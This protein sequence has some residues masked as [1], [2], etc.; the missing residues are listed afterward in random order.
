[1]QAKSGRAKCSN[2]DE[3]HIRAGWLARKKA[4][5]MPIDSIKLIWRID[6]FGCLSLGNLVS[7]AHSNAGS[8]TILQYR[9]LLWNVHGFLLIIFNWISNFYNKFKFND[10]QVNLIFWFDFL[11]FMAVYLIFK[12]ISNFYN[13]FNDFQAYL[14]ISNWIWWFLSEYHHLIVSFAVVVSKCDNG[15]DLQ[16]NITKKKKNLSFPFCLHL[17]L[18]T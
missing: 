18:I 11:I 4:N 5:Y 14:M 8:P 3:I 10:F 1:M 16:N 9:I 13:T 6:F 17:L 15:N 12:W 2:C 7:S